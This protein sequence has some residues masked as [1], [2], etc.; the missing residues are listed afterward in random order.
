MPRRPS[1]DHK[2]KGCGIVLCNIYDIPII[3]RYVYDLWCLYYIMMEILFF[4]CL[5]YN[6]M[7]RLS[8]GGLLFTLCVYVIRCASF[9][10]GFLSYIH[11]VSYVCCFFS[12][13]SFETLIFR[14]EV[15]QIPRTSCN[16]H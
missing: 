5:H 12:Y 13:T 11:H 14:I 7:F 10:I 3:F 9:I 16:L 15:L 4:G 2:G 1:H 8:P 6:L